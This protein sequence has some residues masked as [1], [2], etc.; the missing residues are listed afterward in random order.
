MGHAR[1]VTARERGFC[2]TSHFDVPGQFLC[3]MN[4]KS[5]VNPHL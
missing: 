1:G 3:S 2:L 5:D 4:P